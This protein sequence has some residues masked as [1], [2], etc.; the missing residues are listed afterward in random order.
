MLVGRN[1]K[2]HEAVFRTDAEARD[3]HVAALL[4]G[5]K[6]Q[7]SLGQSDAA[8]VVRGQG[9]V[10]IR[11]EWERNGPMETAFLNEM[12]NLSDPSTGKVSGTLPSGAWLYNGSRIDAD[13][14][15]AATRDASII[16]IIRDHDALVNNPGASRDNDE[17]H[18]PN[19]ARLPEKGHPVRILL[20][21]R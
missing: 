12:V 21:V 4:L 8:A 17:I 14:G 15:F 16:S 13:G 11:V 1:G 6:P 9:A 10:V 5:V 2:L 18:T 3:I 7:S 20:K 19:P